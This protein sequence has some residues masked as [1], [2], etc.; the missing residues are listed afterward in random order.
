MSHLQVEAILARGSG[1]G[2][3]GEMDAKATVRGELAEGAG[4][5][6][7]GLGDGMAVGGKRVGRVGGVV[8]MG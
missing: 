5:V 7:V 6:L 8:R 4:R 2:L 3:G 1:L